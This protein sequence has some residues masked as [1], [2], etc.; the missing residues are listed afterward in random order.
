MLTMLQKDYDEEAAVV[1][2]PPVRPLPAVVRLPPPALVRRPLAPFAPVVTTPAPVRPYG[3]A[4]APV[5]PPPTLRHGG[6][7]ETS[8][9]GRAFAR[10]LGDKLAPLRAQHV[11]LPPSIFDPRV[12]VRS[13]TFRSSDWTDISVD[14]DY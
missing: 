3:L 4:W 6:A 1:H 9:V 8:S 14:S 13:S 5:A 11:P 10:D 12:R 7:R 2:P